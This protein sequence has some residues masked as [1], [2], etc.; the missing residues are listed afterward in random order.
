VAVQSG[1]VDFGGQLF[2]LQLVAGTLGLSATVKAPIGIS[3]LLTFRLRFP[4]SEFI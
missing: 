1:A 3:A 2:L 4:L